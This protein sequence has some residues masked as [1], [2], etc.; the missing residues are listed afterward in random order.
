MEKIKPLLER[1]SRKLGKGSSASLIEVGQTETREHPPAAVRAEESEADFDSGAALDHVDAINQIFAEFEF[2]YHNQYHKAFADTESLAIAK[3]YWLSSLENYL[4]TQIVRAAKKVIRSQD[5]LPSIASL[6]RACEEGFDLFG[7]PAP[8]SA[9][10]EACSAS[11]PK[12]EYQWSHPAVYLAGAATDWFTLANE[13][14]SVAFPR[15]E[16]HYDQLCK[17]VMAGEDL[18]LPVTQALPEK[19][20]RALTAEE[21][22]SRLAQIRRELG[23]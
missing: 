15:F 1:T 12:R 21:R 14:E 7:L 13:R 18:P 6:V 19:T 3:K 5:Y 22:R 4:P 23:I 2:S 10:L 20:E 16:Y 11:S 17:R 8:F 9:Y